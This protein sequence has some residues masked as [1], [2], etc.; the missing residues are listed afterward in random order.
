M[1]NSLRWD[2]DGGDEKTDLGAMGYVTYRRG[3]A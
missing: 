2:E 3:S 1:R